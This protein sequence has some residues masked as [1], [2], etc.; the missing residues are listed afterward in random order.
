MSQIW[1]VATGRPVA[2]II[3]ILLLMGVVGFGTTKL[4]FTAEMRKLAGPENASLTALQEFEAEFSQNNNVLLVISNSNGDL[5]T[6]DILRGLSRIT[7]EAWQI[8]YVSRVDSIISFQYIRSDA[9]DFFVESLL[10]QW[11]N[12]N[13][14]PET[15]A[16]TKQRVL[17]EKTLVNRLISPDGRTTAVNMNVVIPDD[18]TKEVGEI[19]AAVS[20]FQ[21]RLRAD[22]PN[23][24]FYA[25]GNVPLMFT[26]ADAAYRDMSFL[27]PLSFLITGGMVFIFLRQIPMAV[28]VISVLTLATLGAMGF[29][30]WQGQEVDPG[31]VAAPV[32]VMILAMASA[33]HLALG[34]QREL[35]D[36]KPKIEAIHESLASNLFPIFLT[37]TTTA[38]GF[39]AL[40]FADAPTFQ[41]L[42]T[43]V[44][45]GLAFAFVVYFTWFPALLSMLPLRPPKEHRRENDILA[46]FSSF[47]VSYPRTL[48]FVAAVPAIIAILGVANLRL[49]DDFVRYF[50]SRF[51][52]RGASDFTEQHLTGLNIVEY[53]FESGTSEGIYDPDY[54][55]RL[56]AFAT[57]LERQPNVVN[58][59]HVGNILRKINLH[60]HAGDQSFN[61]LPATREE[62]AQY[63]LFYEIN[64][65]P[66][67]DLTD[68]INID[69]SSTKVTAILRNVTSADL[70]QL[71]NDAQ[72]WLQANDPNGAYMEGVSINI[73]FAELA[74]INVTAMLG[75]TFAAL[76]LIS[77]LIM[78]ALRDVRL[79]LWS[80]F[81]NIVPVCLGF[82]L[83]GY[84]V[85]YIGFI[86]AAVPAITLG[87]IVDD[88]IH[89]LI[90]YQRAQ[91]TGASEKEAI[92]YAFKTVGPAM[93]T[94]TVSLVVGF[95]VLLNSGFEIN[96]TLGT[97]TALIITSAL[98]ADL[99]LLPALMLTFG[100]DRQIGMAKYTG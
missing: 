56:E 34:V 71:D 33:I 91:K 52:F 38:I 96:S 29:V 84:L 44:I 13:I 24:E 54:M 72:N 89:F 27:V 75:S 3:P 2:I 98:I 77:F 36:G 93:I 65:R 100:R 26:F 32:I 85:G 23:L 86:S 97:F 57:W 28:A 8:P 35:V 21:D 37:T 31:F 18:A 9:E 19:M 22:F 99:V 53:G 16:E 62:I 15:L 83:W 46:L 76:F 67:L 41:R 61:Q 80:I 82:G 40:N 66:G 51:E 78:I 17:A 64:L 48:F 5:F 95:F 58:V 4:S 79:G 87:I 73:L 81:A 94:T 68:Q 7:E 10:D 70:R 39:F 49:D 25:T 55:K 74:L 45:V 92:R 20:D 59:A 88:T 43:T 63:L 50:D 30:G 42:G 47:V 11:P 90:R 60:M 1:R 69:R 14:P 6:E 12:Q